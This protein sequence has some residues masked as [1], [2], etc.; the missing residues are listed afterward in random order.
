MF[1]GRKYVKPAANGY[2]TAEQVDYI[3]DILK[4][5]RGVR[6]FLWE[7]EGCLNNVNLDNWPAVIEKAKPEPYRPITSKDLFIRICQTIADR[8]GANLVVEKTPH[9]INY[10]DRIHQAIPNA[11]FIVMWRDTYE[12]VLSLK[13][14]IDREPESIRRSLARRHHPLG[15][16]W[17]W[18]GYARSVIKARQ[19]YCNSA[20]FISFN[21]IRNA[22]QDLLSRTIDFLNLEQADIM[23][24][25]QNT[26]FPSGHRPHLQPDDIFWI[27]LL[28]SRPMRDLGVSKRPYKLAP[29]KILISILKVPLWILNLFLSL[30]QIQTARPTAYLFHWIK[31][32]LY[33]FTG[34]KPR[35]F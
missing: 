31:S 23:L 30:R 3:I 19:K 16:A 34:K 5:R 35:S 13:H 14:M 8:E 22:P 26:A 7:K 20:L 27:N 25:G 6:E 29:L 1:W 9:H 15:R 32:G 10:L 24:P 33:I 2:Y 11:Q 17:A 28:C 18:R 4:T 21:E 12:F